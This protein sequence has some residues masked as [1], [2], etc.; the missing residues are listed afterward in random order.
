MKNKK[1]YVS[2]ICVAF[3]LTASVSMISCQKK[4]RPESRKAA[5]VDIETLKSR[6]VL[7]T[8]EDAKTG[9]K[10]SRGTFAVSEDREAQEERMIHLDVVFL[11][12]MELEV[13][14][15][16]LFVFAGGPGANVTANADFYAN[17]WIRE[18]RD[19][20]FVSQRGTG[21]DNRLDCELAKQD[22]NLQ[23]YF[24]PLFRIDYFRPCLEEL[25]DKYDLTKYSTCMAADDYNEVRL[26]LGYGKINIIGTSYGTRMALVYMRRH[27]ETVRAAILN[28]VAPIA[29]KNPLF[30]APGFHEAIRFLMTECADNPDC[31]AAYPNLEE[32][33]ET[34]L[35]QLEKAPVVVN[36]EHPMTKEQ[37][38]IKLS[39]EAF[40]EALRTMMYRGNRQVPFL[41]HKA[42]EGDYVPFA[43]VGLK[44][45][46]SIRRLLAMGL[47]LC[48]TCAEDLD[49][50]TEEEI[51]E[52]T[53]GT[54]M[55]DGRVRRQKAVCEFWPR[56]EI[57]DNYGEPVSV[58]VPVLLLSGTLDPVT[59]PRWGEEA[60]SHLPNSLHLVVP[61]AHGVGNPCLTSIQKQ[62]LETGTLEGLDISCIEALKAGPFHI[63]KKK[64]H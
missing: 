24:D 40:I 6:L 50:I 32:E 11:H 48:V 25:K 47:L 62:F 38:P 53:S 15:D 10:V 14:P 5:P 19:I 42:F 46:R 52:I 13:K 3:I 28:G 2:I 36:V 54:D 61:G 12:S 57:P 35:A 1:R 44:S 41:I 23:S 26:A 33:Y 16:P 31:H 60:A 18:Q 4:E 20:V 9:A 59:P 58:D 30:H 8:E 45:E 63:P 34:I 39:R 27:P 43:Q 55:G 56:S 49:R 51:V 22:D 29:F 17:S 21:G 7:E 37:V 64:K